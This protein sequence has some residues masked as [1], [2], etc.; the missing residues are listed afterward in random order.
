[1]SIT[2]DAAELPA[3]PAAVE[4]AALRIAVEAVTNAVRHSGGRSCRV[5]LGTAGD[6][7]VLEVH[8]DGTSAR[9][10]TPGVGLHAMRERTA[11]LGGTLSAGPAE[12]GGATVTA[13][14]PLPRGRS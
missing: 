10:W 4:V 12:S 9:P 8:D 11:E 1:M 7:L 5:R 14:F 3:L 13:T 6:A 2:V